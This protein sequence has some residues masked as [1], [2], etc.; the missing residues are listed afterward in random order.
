MAVKK[1]PLTDEQ[2]Q[3]LRLRPDWE[4]VD[5]PAELW[6]NIPNLERRQDTVAIMA[7]GSL[8]APGMLNGLECIAAMDVLVAEYR[9][10]LNEPEGNAYHYLFQKFDEPQYPFLMVGPFRGHT[11]IGH[12]FEYH[13]LTTYFE[14]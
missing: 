7:S 12:W 13:D 2:F 6:N 4:I 8:E 14:L 10:Q 11:R 1:T 3:M 5:V 9:R